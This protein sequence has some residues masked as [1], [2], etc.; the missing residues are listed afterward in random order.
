MACTAPSR[1]S[2]R[3]RSRHSPMTTS[4]PPT[5]WLRRRA[6]SACTS[7]SGGKTCSST[8]ASSF[9]ARSPGSIPGASARRTATARTTTGARRTPTPSATTPSRPSR[10]TATAWPTPLAWPGSKPPPAF[11]TARPIALTARLRRK[12][13]RPGHTHE[14][15]SDRAARGPLCIFP[16]GGSTPSGIDRSARRPCLPRSCPARG[17]PKTLQHLRVI[18]PRLRKFWQAGV[19]HGEHR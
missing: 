9:S 2:A 12:A 8:S 7:G 17:S 15:A 10:P 4:A 13:D 6:W 16:P 19:P 11:P 1:S 18:P 5:G 3:A 14:G